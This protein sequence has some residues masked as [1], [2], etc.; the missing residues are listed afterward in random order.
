[1]KGDVDVAEGAREDAAGLEGGEQVVERLPIARHHRRGGAAGA[2]DGQ[3]AVET[4]EDEVGLL[5]RQANDGRASQ[6]GN[7]LHQPAAVEDHPQGVAEVERP[8]DVGRGDLSEALSHDGIGND[9]PGAPQGRQ[10]HLDGEDRRLGDGGLAEAA[11]FR[12]RRQLLQQRP[13]RQ[14]PQDCLAAVDDL[15]EHRL[16]PQQAV[17]HPAPVGALA[18]EEQRQLRRRADRHAGGCGPCGAL[19]RQEG[20]E[21]GARL[22]RR[23][24]RHAQAVLE[25]AAVE[26]GRAADLVQRGGV[27]LRQQLLEG[28]RLRAERL[29]AA[30]REG[31]DMRPTDRLGD[32]VGLRLWAARG[33]LEDQVGVG[34]ADAEAADAGDERAVRRGPGPQLALHPQSEGLEV[35]HRVRGLEMEGSG[36]LPVEEGKGDLDDPRD[37]G[38]RLAVSDVALGRAQCADPAGRPVSLQDRSQ[39]G[40]L[41][42]VAD[43]RAGAVC[44]DVLHLGGGDAGARVRSPQQLLLR[45]AVGRHHPGAAAVLVEGASEEQGVDVPA[46]GEGPA[47]GLEHE[48]T[49]AVAAHDAVGAGVE[50]L[51]APVGRQ[52]TGLG[53]EEVGIGA[54]DEVHSPGEGQRA[55]TLPQ[56]LAGQVE[57]GERARAGGV[58]GEVGTPQVQEVSDS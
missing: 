35:D 38:R 45:L 44:L 9:S 14:L 53:E 28:L 18:G 47:Q 37:P 23:R 48:D 5:L 46:V 56:A 33:L 34:A 24:G 13:A 16:G 4:G 41:D 40:R 54:K 42:R 55:V 58:H 3:R 51:A 15:G 2:G 11:A 32:G 36:D 1:V 7:P 22:R 30:R 31:E 26:S 6:A 49:R 50:G 43:D 12:R 10:R 19:A 27:G 39:R 29:G 21:L 57:G 8:R 52:G 17:A 25:V 20:G